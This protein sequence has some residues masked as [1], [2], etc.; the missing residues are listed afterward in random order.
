MKT[1]LFRSVPSAVAGLFILSLAQSASAQ[2]LPP[3]AE[4]TAAFVDAIG[5]RDA[6]LRN[7]ASL[8]TGTFEMPAAGLKAEI[9]VV[10]EAPDRMGSRIVIPGLGEM[11]TGYDGETGWSLDPMSGARI[12]QGAELD[13]IREQSLALAAVRDPSLFKSMETVERVEVAGKSCYKVKLVWNS[14]RETHDCYDVDNRLLV[15]TWGQTESPMGKVDVMTRVEEYG[16]FGG[17]RMPTKTVQEMMGMQQ[18]LT[19]ANV[20]YEDVDTSLIEPPAEIKALKGAP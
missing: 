16:E 20:S 15:A 17:I 7:K 11:R 13:A 6:V 2:S 4:L 1:L 14:G 9:V 8:A 12:M 18:I 19:I 5:G 3:A 10:T